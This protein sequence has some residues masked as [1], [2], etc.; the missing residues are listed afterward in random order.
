MNILAIDTATEACSAAL[1]R[2]D[3]KVF[4]EF[5]IAPRQHTRL[6]PKM[7]DS[8]L[9]AAACPRSSITHC[10]FSN[11]PGA[12]TGIRIA[13]STAQGIAIALRIPLVP[14][15]T[16]ATLA[17]V[18]FDR[19]KSDSTMVALD[20][21]M[22]EVY[23]AIYR[24]EDGLA[25]LEGKES[26]NRIEDVKPQVVPATGAGHGWTV[27]HSIWSEWS[28]KNQIDIATDLFPD[29]RALLKLAKQAVINNQ[30]VD[31]DKVSINYLRNQVAE[32]SK[33]V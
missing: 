5:E 4:A 3:G 19:Q 9:I 10:A 32:K 7:M 13:A 22:N 27:G 14:I 2:E 24:L 23:W 31:V 17:Q 16:L 28:G 15:S 30:Q 20:A 6:L 29:A 18:S 21:R 8:V 1:L 26:L 12:F 25:V 11:G 33:K